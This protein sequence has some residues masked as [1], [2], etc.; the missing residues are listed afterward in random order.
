MSIYAILGVN[1]FSEKFP[2]NFSRTLFSMFQVCTGDDCV[3]E[4][5]ARPIMLDSFPDGTIAIGACVFFVSFIVVV[6]LILLQVAVAVLLDNF[7]VSFLCR[8]G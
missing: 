6:A 4:E 7:Y 2:V 3:S 1:F 5:L 8:E